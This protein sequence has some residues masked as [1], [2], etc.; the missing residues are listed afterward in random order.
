MS[1]NELT[2]KLSAFGITNN[3]AKVYLA[4][5]KLGIAPVSQIS[6]GSHVPREEVYRMLPQLEKMGLIEKT[7][8]RPIRIKATKIESVLTILINRERDMFSKK[9]AELKAKRECIL[10]DFRRIRME[11]K[12]EERAHITWIIQKHAVIQK[13]LSMIGAAQ[14]KIDIAISRDQFVYL[15]ANYSTLIRTTLSRG[16]ELRIIVEKTEY[17][18][19]IHEIV[20]K[21]ESPPFSFDIRFV[22]QLQ[23]HY[24][25]IDSKESLVSTS[26][27][28]TAM[29]NKAY[30]WIDEN[31]I[32]QLILQNFE[33]MWLTSQDIESMKR[34]DDNQ[35]LINIINTLQPSEH[36]ILVFRSMEAKHDVLCNYLKIGLEN[37]EAV[38]YITSDNNHNPIKDVLKRFGIDVEKNQKTG[39]LVIL[40]YDEFYIFDGKFDISTTKRLLRQIYDDVME[41]GFKGCRVFGEMSCFFNYG[42]DHKL[43]EY[44][45]SLH[46]IFDIPIIGLCAYNADDF[47]KPD[48]SLELYNN[49]LNAHS[50]VL[51]T[52]LDKT[53]EKLLAR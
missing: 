49:L 45:R 31:E 19:T 33:M 37:G 32:I 16:I 25:L 28:A 27:E 44:E 17:D 4:T 5:A 40:G 14:R 24:F 50:T 30:L 13:I 7:V 3:Q 8:E 22:D 23:S 47:D 26:M 42:L 21:I 18:D 6:K 15:F 20:N 41:K 12:T 48:S 11:P 38:V 10:G 9:M 52:G 36:I 1:F 2:E 29:G 51:F 35:K 39:A 46:R 43:I 34:M 53:L